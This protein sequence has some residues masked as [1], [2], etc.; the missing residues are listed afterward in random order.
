MNNPSV[1]SAGSLNLDFVVQVATLPQ[2]GE[3][4]PG[5]GFLTLPGGKGA[6]GTTRAAGPAAPS[7][8]QDAR[9][10]SPGGTAAGQSD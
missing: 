8:G 6:K 5:S 7:E 2:R 9:K 10:V 4:L 1:I 3:T